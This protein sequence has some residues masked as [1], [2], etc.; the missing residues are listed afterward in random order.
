MN[1]LSDLNVGDHCIIKSFNNDLV[2]SKLISMGVYPESSAQIID[3]KH[4]KY[5]FF[6]TVGTLKLAL[7][8]SEA[9]SII[10]DKTGSNE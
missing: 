6:I 10:V 9:A 4:N 8:N 3:T 7:L 5:A 1:R 2:A